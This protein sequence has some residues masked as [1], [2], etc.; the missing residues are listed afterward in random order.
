MIVYSELD[1]PSRMNY[2]ADDLRL[3]PR[4]KWSIYS[5]KCK[6]KTWHPRFGWSSALSNI[7]TKARIPLASIE[8]KTAQEIEVDF[9]ESRR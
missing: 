3:N 1:I 7:D 5:K 9:D 2:F 4:N 6:N 8:K